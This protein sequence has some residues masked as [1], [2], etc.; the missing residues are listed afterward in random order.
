MNE[1]QQD[2]IP[3]S[4]GERLRAGRE[5]RGL[6]EEDVSR[7]LK[8]SVEVIRA[9]EADKHARLAPVYRRGFVR[10]Y[11]EFLDIDPALVQSATDETYEESSALR[12]VFPEARQLKSSDRWLRVASYALASLLVGTLAWQVTH[13]AARLTNVEGD[14]VSAAGTMTPPPSAHV[15]ASIASLESLRVPAAARAG[16]GRQAWQAVDNGL[17]NA[18]LAE[19]EHLLELHA[20]ADSWVEIV[21]PDGQRL[22]RDLVRGG[23]KRSYRG[24]APFDLSIGR[25]SAIQ[26]FLDGESVDLSAHA[27]EDVARLRLDPAAAPAESEEVAE[28]PPQES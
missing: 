10:A 27:R 9:I 21:G 22:E 12:S 13:E 23:E 24:Q 6:S 2:L 15:S 25:S 16:A 3:L 17:A 19:G 18:P 14:S 11:A 8:C 5:H 28:Q 26:L 20:S 4:P 7:S 1:Q